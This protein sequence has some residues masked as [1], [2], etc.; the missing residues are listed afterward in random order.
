MRGKSENLRMDS[1]PL[2]KIVN[3]KWDSFQGKER[4]EFMALARCFHAY[5]M[6]NFVLH[7]E[8]KGVEFIQNDEN[9][10]KD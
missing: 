3:Q 6:G 2:I 10:P 7:R 9:L 5:V 8:E 1:R 4:P